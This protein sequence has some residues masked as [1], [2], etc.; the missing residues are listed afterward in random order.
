[1]GLYKRSENKEEPTAEG[2]QAPSAGAAQPQAAAQTR[3]SP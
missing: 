2:E 3:V 1:M